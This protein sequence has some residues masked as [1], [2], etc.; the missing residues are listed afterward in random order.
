MSK[1]ITLKFFLIAMFTLG[2]CAGSQAQS[3][4]GTILGLVKDTSGAIVPAAQVNITNLDA[5]HTSTTVSD[6]HG[7]Y[8]I[9]NLEPAHY[10][11][12]VI[13][14]GFE[15]GIENDLL[16]TARQQLRAD[17]VLR[18]GVVSQQVVVDAAGAGVAA[19][20]CAAAIGSETD[21]SI[22]CPSSMNGIVGIKPTLGLLSRSGIIPISHSQDTAG[23]MA[24]TVREA[25]ILLSVLTG[26]DPQDPATRDSNGHIESRLHNASSTPT[27][28][29][30]RASAWPASSWATTSPSTN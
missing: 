21:G 13:K 1:S 5:G 30:A 12:E 19:N 11:V 22:V 14:N 16:L 6:A 24:R 2:F 29:A 17:I 28:S 9:L 26:A 23:P 27:A 3:T 8:Q 7:N 18:V 10:K 4:Q 15:A 25:A 20:F